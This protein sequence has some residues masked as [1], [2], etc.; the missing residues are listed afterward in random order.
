MSLPSCGGGGGAGDD[1]E[2][3][4]LHVNGHSHGAGSF[5][6][7][8]CDETS[9]ETPSA[10]AP[11]VLLIDGVQVQTWFGRCAVA[12]KALH[13]SSPAG[14]ASLPIEA[15]TACSALMAESYGARGGGGG[16]RGVCVG[17]LQRSAAAV[18][19]ARRAGPRP[20]PAPLPQGTCLARVAS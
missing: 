8:V 18:L 14:G 9:A 11:A 13:E 16:R 4:P 2:A 3:P 1:A 19:S 10:V 5:L 12:F 6:C 20:R 17:A 7:A 15:A